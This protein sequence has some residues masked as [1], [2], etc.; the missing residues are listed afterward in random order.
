M[1]IYQDSHQNYAAPKMTECLK[2]EGERIAEKTVG[3]YMREMG[4]KA[5]YRKPYTVTTIKPD[6]AAA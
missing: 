2:Q 5:Q 4:I 6:L 1:E 3:H